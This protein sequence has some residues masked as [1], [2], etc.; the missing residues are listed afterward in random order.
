MLYLGENSLS[1]SLDEDQ[2]QTLSKLLSHY[3]TKV[4]SIE[5][6]FNHH[7][8]KL[9]SQIEHDLSASF[10]DFSGELDQDLSFGRMSLT[11]T[12][13]FP[14]LAH[15]TQFPEFSASNVE[16]HVPVDSQIVAEEAFALNDSNNSSLIRSNSNEA[17]MHSTTDDC[18][19]T[20]NTNGAANVKT[21][22]EELDHVQ[23]QYAEIVAS[24]SH[25]PKG[26]AE[27]SSVHE[28]AL[29]AQEELLEQEHKLEMDALQS[30][31]D[32]KLQVEL[33][34]QAIE[35]LEKFQAGLQSNDQGKM[36][37]KRCESFERELVKRTMT[38]GQFD[39]YDANDQSKNR[40]GAKKEQLD[41]PFFAS[42]LGSRNRQD[43][44][45]GLVADYEARIA[46]MQAE[47]EQRFKK[48]RKELT[49]LSEKEKQEITAK[50]KNEIANLQSQLSDSEEKYENLMEGK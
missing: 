27:M 10:G 7:M 17:V 48:L 23:N 38:D 22:Q 21:L 24:E 39:S 15:Q 29:K 43:D 26:K 16:Q 6:R 44:S 50:L 18:R 45:N 12:S 1:Q 9:K 47:F 49:E 36:T 5:E 37:L 25:L 2:R 14:Q 4:H 40:A 31:C 30:E 46:S 13:R 20:S 28:K 19:Y 3:E 35:L 34:K 33:K 41:V 11:K 32:I 42:V 8:D